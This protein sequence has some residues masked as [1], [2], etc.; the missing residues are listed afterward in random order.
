[1]SDPVVSLT[2]AHGV[3]E[4]AVYNKHKEG[5]REVSDWR[6]WT[7]LLESTWFRMLDRIKE[8]HEERRFITYHFTSSP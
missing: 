5:E 6:R 4:V 3:Q 8:T 7:F 1:V 2:Q